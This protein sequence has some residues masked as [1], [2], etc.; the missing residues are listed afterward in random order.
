VALDANFRLKRKK[1]SSDEADAG[2]SKGWAYVVEE[3]AYKIHLAKYKNEKEPVRT[4]SLV[5]TTL[6]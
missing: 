5:I 3:S 6:S 1:V 4:F 2:L